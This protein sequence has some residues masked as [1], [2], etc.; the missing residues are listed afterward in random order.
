MSA[1]V[2]DGPMTCP[3]CG[4]DM[5]EDTRERTISISFSGPEGE[6]EMAVDAGES[7]TIKWVCE[8]CL[9]T[10][11]TEQRGDPYDDQEDDEEDDEEDVQAG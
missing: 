2:S 11:T 10:E 1:E 9:W 4:G 6:D 7:D 8:T 5:I 3:N